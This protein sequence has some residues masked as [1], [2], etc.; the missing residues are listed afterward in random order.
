M[1]LSPNTVTAAATSVNGNSIVF[2]TSYSNLSNAY[3]NVSLRVLTGGALGDLR[4]ITSYDGATKTAFVNLNFSA[5]ISSGDTLSLSY[6]AKDVDSLVQAVSSK[7]SFNVAMDVS[8]S[9]RDITNSTIITDVNKNSLIFTLPETFI[10]NNTITNAD[11]VSRK[12]FAGVT[13]TSNAQYTFVLTAGNE[14]YNFGSDGSS[15]SATTANSNIIVM[16]KDKL[17]SNATNG[18]IFNLTAAG[19][20]VIRNSSTQLTIYAGANNAFVGD[21][22]VNV[23]VSNS[24]NNRRSKQTVRGNSTLTALR[25]TDLPTNGT[26]VIGAPTVKIDVANGFIWFTDTSVIN[27]IPSGN[28]SLYVA[29]VFKVVKV[30]D[31]GNP[32]YPPNTVNAIDITSRFFLD[33]GQN[34]NYYDHSRL[35]LKSGSSAPKGQMVAMVQYYEHTG[36]GYFNVDSY[37]TTHY[38]NSTIPVFVDADGMKYNLR[39]AIDFRPTRDIGTSSNVATAYTFIGM[40]T[41]SPKSSD[42]MEMTY[43]YYI[44]RIDKVILTKD[45][46]LKVLTGVASK[47]PMEPKDTD[48]AMTLFRL[49]IPAYTANPTDVNITK[50]ENRRYTMR[51]IGNLETRIKNIEYY[52]ALS[53]SEKKATDTTVLY[54]DNATAKEKYGIVADNFTGFNIADTTSPDFVCSLEKGR[55]SAYAVM[56]QIPMVVSSVGADA[57]LNTKTA[58]VGYTEQTIIAQTAATANTSVQPY[59][60]GVFDGSMKLSP[61]GDSWF[62]TNLAPIAISPLQTIPNLSSASSVVSAQQPIDDATI[63][64]WITASGAFGFVPIST[65]IDDWFV[66]QVNLGL[67][68][69]NFHI[70]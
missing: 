69:T 30:F 41:P 61:D 29:D 23:K 52:T 28:N 35:I 48:N 68:G 62:S 1:Q 33:S 54:E 36:T 24:Q 7:A 2:P 58:S 17:T 38:A 55:M 60:Y 5:N 59:L 46:E 49:D 14:T 45:R 43:S 37:P 31:S 67:F 50:I 27:K 47:Y 18:A 6:G 20:G 51:D 40:K 3:A 65:S 4:T 66:S 70:F 11:Y 63:Q 44:P 42:T 32:S 57:K 9:S 13:F 56:T 26:A 12:L 25:V 22:Y 64:S 34:K 53:I 39:D 15:L 19:S 10:A 16:V 8:G 21:V